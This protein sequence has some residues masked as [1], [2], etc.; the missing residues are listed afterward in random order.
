M[1]VR[2]RVVLVDVGADLQAAIDSL[3][4]AGGI[5]RLAAGTYSLTS[6]LTIPDFVTLEGSGIDATILSWQG[7]AALKDADLVKVQGNHCAIKDL[8]IIGYEPDLTYTGSTLNDPGVVTNAQRAVVVARP[9]TVNAYNDYNVNNFLMQRV[10]IRCASRHCLVVGQNAVDR[11]VTGVV[12]LGVLSKFDQCWFQCCRNAE[13][14]ANVQVIANSTTITFTDCYIQM[15]H[16]GAFYADNVDGITF[17]KCAFE[18]SGFDNIDFVL[19]GGATRAIRFI[20]CWFEKHGIWATRYFMRSNGR[21]HQLLVRGCIFFQDDLTETKP[22][23]LWAYGSTSGGQPITLRAS[24]SDNFC[25]L[26]STSAPDASEAFYLDVAG[27]TV[28]SNNNTTIN[29]QYAGGESSMPEW[30]SAGSGTLN[31]LVYP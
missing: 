23:I 8:T 31:T 6:T 12:S 24:F 3:G 25:R 17:D 20:D 16:N 26:A 9:D 22:H 7:V 15:L 1:Q 19:L 5:I 13:A 18:D 10:F 27:D 30:D 4:M 14:Y 11:P 28:M 29:G 21:N 2:A